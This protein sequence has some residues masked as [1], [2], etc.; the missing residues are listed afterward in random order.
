[1]L[2]AFYF[3][4]LTKACP[5]QGQIQGKCWVGQ[6]WVEFFWI[7]TSGKFCS[8]CIAALRFTWKSMRRS[9]PC[10]CCLLQSLPQ[11]LANLAF[12][13]KAACGGLFGW[14]IPVVQV[15]DPEYGTKTELGDLSVTMFISLGDTGF[16]LVGPFPWHA[17]MDP[18]GLPSL[19]PL[20]RTIMT[21]QL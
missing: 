16:W 12:L 11:S 1:M 7:S 15:R 19:L 10:R 8:N 20:F 3:S 14:Q 18:I 21:F 17:L 13:A 4:A 5:W 9:L 2:W 6:T